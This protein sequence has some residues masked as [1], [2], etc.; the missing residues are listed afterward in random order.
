MAMKDDA[1][2]REEAQA[3]VDAHPDYEVNEQNQ[4]ELFRRLR[5][6]DLDC[7]RDNLARVYAEMKGE[8]KS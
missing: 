8:R 2:Y 6:L 3:F 7:T 1:Y 4:A 5:K